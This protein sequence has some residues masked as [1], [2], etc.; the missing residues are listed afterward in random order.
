MAQAKP[1]VPESVDVVIVGAGPVGLTTANLLGRY[2]VS[3]LVVEANDALIDFPRG[4]GIDDETLRTFQTAGLI[5]RVL[6][7]TV[8]NHKTRIVNGAGRILAEIAP[9]TDEFGWPRKNGFIQPLID[10]ELLAGLD[11]YPQVTVQFGQQVTGWTDN[12]DHVEATVNEGSARVR[13]RY[14]VGADGG[15][16]STRRLMGVPFEGQSSSTR[17]L[18]VDLRTDPLGHPNA[19]LGADPERPFV[20]IS[21]PHGIRR[22]EFMLF[23]GETDEQAQE[24]AFVR[25]LMDKLAPGAPAV[26]MIRSRV[27]I[28]HSR[29]AGSF[30]KGRVLIAGDAA[31]L[32]PVWQGQ[33]FNS[34]VRDAFNLAWKLAAVVQG[35]ASGDLLDSYDAERR[36]HA[37]AMIKLSTLLG[38][39]VSPTNKWIGR[40]RDAIAVGI[41]AVP[42]LKS[43]IVNMRFKPMPRYHA[44]AIVPAR[45]PDSPVGRLFPQ[46]R[47]ST[48]TKPDVLLDDVL[49][50]WFSLLIWNNNPHA[51]LDDDART[52]LETLGVRLVELRPASQV[53]W[54]G[55][56]HDDV[57]VAGDTTGALKRFFDAHDESVVLVRPDR[58]VVAACP[59]YRTSAVVRDACAALHADDV[60]TQKRQEVSR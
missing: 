54:A 21:L 52:R 12:G 29:I 57:T 14:L 28:H 10:R 35:R 53:H 9:E 26:D 3:V 45:T 44:G 30:R 25:R 37:L 40:A 39:V 32:M 20:S 38:K 34:G 48:R 11:R 5:D 56:D 7:H 23:D 6:P 59:A 31:H 2:G 46:P 4:V 15:R 50:D 13:A 51:L 19:Y 60:K 27:Y 43:Y 22:F 58:V 8:P 49:G 55:H 24:P 33:G 1:V 17:W 16:S 18:V 41:G 42:P 36:D 47:V